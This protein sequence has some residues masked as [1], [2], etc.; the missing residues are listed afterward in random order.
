MTTTKARRPTVEPT[1]ARRPKVPIVIPGAEHMTP[2]E[3]K[4]A[5]HAEKMRRYLARKS[6]SDPGDIKKTKEEV[7]VMSNQEL[8]ELSKDSR[9]LAMRVINKKLVALDTD[10]E[11]L[12]KINIAT[13]A[14]A[15]GILF[16]K[17][18]LMNGLAT[19]NVAIH[20]KIDIN[21]SS[22]KAMEELN[23]MREKYAEQNS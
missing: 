11:Q 15:F 12:A 8:M 21:M 9:N 18:Q 17:H 23:K 2:E 4:K 1:K 5:K 20:Q 14:T 3:L 16:D 22:D 6:G 13:L 19:E 10:P 7:M